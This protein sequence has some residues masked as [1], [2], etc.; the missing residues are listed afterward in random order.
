MLVIGSATPPDGESIAF[1]A[2]RQLP[3]VRDRRS[4]AAGE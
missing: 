4:A 2:D 1:F 3:R